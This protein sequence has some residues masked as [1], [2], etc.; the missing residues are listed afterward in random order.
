MYDKKSIIIIAAV[1]VVGFV[2]GNVFGGFTDIA[3]TG[4][5]VEE[6]PADLV[7]EPNGENGFEEAKPQL[8]QQLI[9]EKKQELIK[10]HMEELKEEA[11]V[12][13]Y[14]DDIDEGD[15]SAVVAA[16]NGA[17][18]LKEE[19]LAMEEQEKQQME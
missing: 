12:E 14:L 7:G 17:E 1:L 5:P 8:K 13:T 10:E 19:L 15:E 3:G 6:D 11:T 16:V 9:Q 2:L 18:I 4:E